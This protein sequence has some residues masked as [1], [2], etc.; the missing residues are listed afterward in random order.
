MKSLKVNL[1]E[2]LDAEKKNIS[3]Y[4]IANEV[5]DYIYYDLRNL[6][7]EE[8]FFLILQNWIIRNVTL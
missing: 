5:Q 2:G 4:R 3:V 7:D 8:D 6:C 1:N